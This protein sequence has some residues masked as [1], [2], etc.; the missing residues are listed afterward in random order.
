MTI[1]KATALT[2]GFIGAFALGV[3]VGPSMIDRDRTA[4]PTTVT[5]QTAP[6]DVER[7]A[8]APSPSPR[9]VAERKADARI[10]TQ[11]ASMST[12]S[13]DLHARLKPVLNRGTKMDLAAEGFRDAE[14]FATV[15]HASRNT[16]IPFVVLKHRV[17]TE[18][19]SLAD[20]ID[21]AK[22][23]VDGK[24]EATRARTEA[25]ADLE[26]ISG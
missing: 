5:T 10:K 8:P 12:G 6:A 14:Q 19:Q 21:A 2:A 13:P 18:G 16:A 1:G 23:G 7:P 22:P 4:T 20:A 17:V 11:M 3:A 25:R 9:V 15:A 24:R 26:S